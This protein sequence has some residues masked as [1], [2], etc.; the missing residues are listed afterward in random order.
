MKLVLAGGGVVFGVAAVAVWLF[1]GV[2]QGADLGKIETAAAPA[3][4]ANRFVVHEWGTFTSFSG[5]DGVPVGFQPNNSDLPSFIYYQEG[6]ANSKESRLSRGGTVSMETP[7]LYCYSDRPLRASI[8]VD[9]PKGWIT[10]W[11]PFASVPP[12]SKG[13]D[14]HA[15]GQSMRWDIKLLPGEPVRFAPTRAATPITMPVKPRLRR[16]R[17]K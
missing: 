14:P 17:L 4:V 7:V 5:S 1:L 16:W 2:G 8:T 3:E 6:A 10:E 15:V 11:Y 13:N 12:R 9:F